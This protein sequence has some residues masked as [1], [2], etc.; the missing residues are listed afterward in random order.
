[1]NNQLLDISPGPARPID[2]PNHNE[3]E[4]MEEITA[5]VKRSIDFSRRLKLDKA[6]LDFETA[7]EL[8]QMLS[9][10]LRTAKALKAQERSNCIHSID[11]DN[12][13]CRFCGIPE[14]ELRNRA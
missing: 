6:Q 7:E 9:D 8:L 3:L 5:R 4:R 11:R 10:G 12:R 13:R 2:G 1:M 14:K